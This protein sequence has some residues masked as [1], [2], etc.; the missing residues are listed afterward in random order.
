MLLGNTTIS[1]SEE[2]K[3]TGNKHIQISQTYYDRQ[4]KIETMPV[5]YEQE[6]PTELRSQS[7]SDLRNE[8]NYRE[9]RD[10][11]VE[12]CQN[13]FKSQSSYGS[14]GA[15]STYYRVV[16]NDIY[17]VYVDTFDAC[18]QKWTKVDV[19]GVQRMYDIPDLRNEGGYPQKV[20]YKE[21]GQLCRYSK[22][23]RNYEVR[24]DC[25]DY[26]QY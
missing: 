6:K 3:P 10:K 26:K 5:M 25:F 1:K 16:E 19:I 24:K 8:L 12:A 18:S 14:D 7:N 11:N 9:Q 21:K 23:D 2:Q 15:A 13:D 20:Y 17:K 22:Y 4:M